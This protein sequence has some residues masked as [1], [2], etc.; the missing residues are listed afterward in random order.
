MTPQARSTA[1]SAPI[2]GA[3]W[4]LLSGLAGGALLVLP[5]PAWGWTA[6]RAFLQF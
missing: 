4:V 1:L 5:I 6:L 2:S 3:I